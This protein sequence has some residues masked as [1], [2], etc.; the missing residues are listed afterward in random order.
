[1]N[2]TVEQNIKMRSS[3]NTYRKEE[4]VRAVS[5]GLAETQREKLKKISEGVEYTTRSE[6][7]EKLVSLKEAYF[8]KKTSP[9]S[10]EQQPLF[11]QTSKPATSSDMAVYT[12]TLS[13]LKKD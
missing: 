9:K 7:A 1:L 12:Q 4:V 13:K 2:E 5:G 11:E 8:T 3:L 10:E 6:F